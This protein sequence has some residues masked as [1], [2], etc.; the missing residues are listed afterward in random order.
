MVSGGQGR[1]AMMNEACRATPHHDIAACQPATARAVLALQTS[2][3]KG[4]RSAE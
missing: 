1:D 3:E 4:C 2:P